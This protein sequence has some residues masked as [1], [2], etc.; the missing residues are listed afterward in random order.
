MPNDP[1]L[2]IAETTFAS[3]AIRYRYA[4]V[5]SPDGTRWVRHG[6]FV[7]YA[8]SGVVVSEGQYLNGRE[9]GA[10]QDFYPSGRLAA[11][12]QYEHGEEVGTWE[13]WDEQGNPA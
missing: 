3:G 4:R 6:L 10:W 5:L 9:H 12:G 2:H 8:E 11:R 13:Y 7:E 1:D